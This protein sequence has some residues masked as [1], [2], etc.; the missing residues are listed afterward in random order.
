MRISRDA[1]LMTIAAAVAMRG[2]CD[3][4][5]VGAVASL[6]G[7][8]I[9]T[10]YNGSPSGLPHCKHEKD[11]P[12]DN[13]VHAEANLVAFAARHGVCLFN[14]TVYTTV[15]PC[16]KCAELLIN[17][18]VKEVIFGTPHRVLDGIQLLELAGI[19]VRIFH[20]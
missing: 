17:S 5:Y 10:G 1:M 19:K 15:S 12:C 4:A 3:R 2:T 6:D 7:R 9:C 13:A 11:L 18:G 14:S 8:V 20:E 16:K